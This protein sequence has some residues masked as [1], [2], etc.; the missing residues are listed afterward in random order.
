MLVKR[1]RNE[2]GPTETGWLKSQHSFSFGRYFDPDHM[3]FGPLRVINEDWVI[4]GAGFPTHPHDN[5]EIIT[6]VL[7]GELAHKDSMGNGSVIKPG[8]IQVMSAGSGV[9]H[10][11]FNNSDRNE[12][13]LLQIWIMPNVKNATP[14]YQ[15]KTFSS[16]VRNEFRQVISSEGPTEGASNTLT[17]RQN[18][19]IYVGK[20]DEDAETIF[21]ADSARR[22]WVQVARGNVQVNGEEARAGDGFAIT[23]EKEISVKASTEA[24]ILL[25]DLP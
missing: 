5:M 25:F 17:I 14:G 21:A 15:Q 9:T 23:N 8:D 2:R 12:V 13:H 10:S 19:G 4:P 1:D 7:S 18:A 24:E 22:Y 11:E 20:F 3:G 6:Y 16:D